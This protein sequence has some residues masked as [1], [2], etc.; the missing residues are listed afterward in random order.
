MTVIASIPGLVLVI[1]VAFL[2]LFLGGMHWKWAPVV[3]RVRWANLR[4]FN[5]TQMDTAGHPGAFAQVLRHTGRTSGRVYET[6]L[7]IEPTEDGF[8]IA[9][10]YGDR[11]QWSKNVLAAGHAEVVRDDIIYEVERPEI[12]PL[13]DVAGYLQPS[14]RRMMGLFGVEHALRLYH[15][16]HD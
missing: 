8:V 14:D 15:A 3:D 13:A 11:T 12:V 2:G 1:L 7:G 6:P 5:P 16:D 10:V 9:M 4:F